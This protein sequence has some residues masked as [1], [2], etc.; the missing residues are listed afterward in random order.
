MCSL[1]L[2]NPEGDKKILTFIEENPNSNKINKAFFNVA[3]YYF[4]NKKAAYA[5]K[6]VPQS[7]Y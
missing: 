3:N 7:K 5:L 1:R 6:M 2:N 4:A